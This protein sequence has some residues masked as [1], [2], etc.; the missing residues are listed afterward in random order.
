MARYDNITDVEYYHSYMVQY[1]KLL[2]VLNS[3]IINAIND[4]YYDVLNVKTIDACLCY[5]ENPLQKATDIFAGNVVLNIGVTFVMSIENGH[6]Q[7]KTETTVA[8]MR[9]KIMKESKGKQ[10]KGNLKEKPQRIEREILWNER[11][12][13]RRVL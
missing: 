1:N 9:E 4:K 12:T 10:R 11:L 5:E 3:T 13:I 7:N 2:L 8:R 6:Y